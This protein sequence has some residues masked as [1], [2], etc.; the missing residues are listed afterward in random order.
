MQPRTSA[1]DTKSLCPL[2]KMLSRRESWAVVSGSVIV[3]VW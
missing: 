1:M 2:A 3:V